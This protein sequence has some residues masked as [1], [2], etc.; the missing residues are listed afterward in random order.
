[1]AAKIQILQLSAKPQQETQLL[2]AEIGLRE[3]PV[4]V[5]R[6]GR[7]ISASRTSMAIS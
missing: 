4:T 6:V 2:N 7:P 5:F 3:R 1:M